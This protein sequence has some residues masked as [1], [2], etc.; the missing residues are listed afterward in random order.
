MPLKLGYRLVDSPFYKLKS[1][2][3]LARLLRVSTETLDQLSS[4]RM[5]YARRWKH[6]KLEKWL[7]Q[8]PSEDAADIYRPIDI[9]DPCLKA[10]QS[11]IASLLS[12]I[13][14]PDFLFS[15]VK[16]RSYVE[17]AARHVG[18]EAF[19]LLDIADYFPSCAANKVARFFRSDLDCSPDVSAVLVRLT[20]HNECLPQGSPCSPILAYYC[21]RPMWLAIEKIVTDAGCKLSLYADDITISGDVVRKSMIWEVKKIVHGNGLRLKAS[22][23]VSLIKSAADIT[24]VIVKPDGTH[25]PNRQFK[26]L[27]ELKALHS[28]T[29]NPKDKARI[30]NQISGRIAQ[31]RQ[32]ESFR[33][34]PD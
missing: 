8:P 32:V 13:H 28:T 18:S 26:K 3:K 17:N 7:C 24:G 12:R 21:N 20:T 6:K 14:P 34:A 10:V 4:G 1:R 5:L 33:I 31:W 16:G 22:K 9:P 2:S 27:A 29:V 23:E 25:L 30:E 19:W 15:P 11:R